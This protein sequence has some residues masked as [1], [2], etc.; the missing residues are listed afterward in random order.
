VPRL[1]PVSEPSCVCPRN[2]SKIWSDPGIRKVTRNVLTDFLRHHLVR[3]ISKVHVVPI[4]V[5]KYG[6]LMV[7]TSTLTK[8]NI[9]LES[10]IDSRLHL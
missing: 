3:C 4:N 7:A 6:H 8:T 2:F 9:S 10:D 5:S 1:N